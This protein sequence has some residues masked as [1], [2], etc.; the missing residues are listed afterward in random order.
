MP[1][2]GG[3]YTIEGATADGTHIFSFAFDMPDIGDAEGEEASFVFAVPVQAG[4]ADALAT[5]T[6][7]GP[8]G[9]ATLDETTDHPM[10]IL[11]DPRTG[12]CA[13]FCRICRPRPRRRRTRWSR[14]LGKGWKCCSAGAFPAGSLEAVS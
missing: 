7:S 5:I 12:R 1:S 9:S 3:E 6:L 11:R 2:A 13:A 8:G 4:W 10:A 14:P